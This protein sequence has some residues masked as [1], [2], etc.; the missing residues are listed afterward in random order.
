M[1]LEEEEDQEAKIKERVD[2]I[3]QV[4]S[5][6]Q[7]ILKQFDDNLFNALVEKITILSPAHFVFTLKSGMSIDEIIE[8]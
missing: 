1:I 8:N 7:D 4:L 5:L 2:E 3:I 6:R